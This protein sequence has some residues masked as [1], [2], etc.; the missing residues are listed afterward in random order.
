MA[1]VIEARGVKIGE[2]MPKIIV[3]IVG[4]SAEEV[5]DFARSV[6]DAGPDIVEWRADWFD[7]VF[8]FDKVADVLKDLRAVLGDTPILFTFRTAKEGGEKEIAPDVYAKLNADAAATGWID[9]VD[10]EIFTGDDVV[11]KIIDDAHSENVKVIASNHDFE[12]TPEKDELISRLKK[13]QEMGAD[14]LKLAVMPADK[15]DVLKLL[16]ATE[17]MAAEYADC[18]MITMSMGELG[19]ISRICGEVFGSAATFG[20]VGKVSAPG[21]MDIDKLRTVLKAM[22][23]RG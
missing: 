21:Q 20:A 4:K 8:A 14:I 1:K 11:R 17:E 7:G 5:L 2:G 12:K 6:R 15:K 9:L 23:D 3:P 19:R 16:V 18:P 22:R 10:V 13:M